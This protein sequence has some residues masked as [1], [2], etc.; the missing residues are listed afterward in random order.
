MAIKLAT[1]EHSC[2]EKVTRSSVRT[3]RQLG[4]HE[5]ALNGWMIRLIKRHF[6]WEIH[7]NRF[8]N[9]VSVDK[10]LSG[11][12]SLQLTKLSLACLEG[13]LNYDGTIK[14]LSAAYKGFSSSL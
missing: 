13:K 11:G 6:S 9:S 10:T 1:K 3:K 14:S 4:V 7:S 5:I 8:I 2:S 12:N